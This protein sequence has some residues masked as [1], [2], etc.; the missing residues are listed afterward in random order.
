MRDRQ[1]LVLRKELIVEVVGWE[2]NL[3]IAQFLPAALSAA[4]M[5]LE[6]M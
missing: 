4:N 1:T 6:S 2:V 3:M 5:E